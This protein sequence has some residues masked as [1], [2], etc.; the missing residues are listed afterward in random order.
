[1]SFQTRSDIHSGE[2]LGIALG[3]VVPPAIRCRH[4]SCKILIL[5]INY[6]VICMGVP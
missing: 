2:G 3:M 6:R 4:S 1:M 5:Y